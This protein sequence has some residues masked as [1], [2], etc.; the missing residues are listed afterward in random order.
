MVRVTNGI[1]RLS[2]GNFVIQLNNV[3]LKMTGNPN[4]PDLQT[5]TTA[6]GTKRDAYVKMVSEARYGARLSIM[7]R[8]AFRRE[9]ELDYN[10]LGSAVS[11]VAKGDVVMLESS[12]FAFS[13]PAQPTAPLYA[14][15]APLLSAGTNAGD[16]WCKAFS[17]KGGTG[18]NLFV[19]ADPSMDTNWLLI[20]NAQAK[21][22][23]SGLES[24]VRQYFKYQLKGVRKQVVTSSIS[25]FIPQ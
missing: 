1:N 14:P 21:T 8:N 25:S 6:L 19:T 4:Y 15:P 2:E 9:I 17:Q 16:I 24:G 13:Q 20:P 12:G 18:F 11:A 10:S 3:C 7:K 23:V 22:L 5:G